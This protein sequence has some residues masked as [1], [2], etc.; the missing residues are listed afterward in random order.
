MDNISKIQNKYSDFFNLLIKK[1]LNK[2][3]K[4]VINKN[5]SIDVF[6]DDNDFV[7]ENHLPTIFLNSNINYIPPN[8]KFHGNLDSSYSLL[9]KIGSN[10]IADGYIKINIDSDFEGIGKGLCAE[11]LYIYCRKNFKV[12]PSHIKIENKITLMNCNIQEFGENIKAK[13]LEIKCYNYRDN[14]YIKNINNL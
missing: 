11:S 7:R 5:G 2:G 9:K 10:V 3:I 13:S 12:F 1:E 8:I 4:Y 14:Y 6:C